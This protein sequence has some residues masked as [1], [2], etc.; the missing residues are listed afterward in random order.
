MARVTLVQKDQ[1]SKEVEEVFR[2]IEGNG[3]RVLNLYKAVAVSPPMLS[4][5]LKLGNRLL[6][7]AELSSKLRELAILR[8]ANLAGS[9]YEWTQHLSIALATGVSQQQIDDVHSW[10]ESASFTEEE[11][12]VLQYTDELAVDVTVTEGTFDGLRSHLSERQ[13]VELTL[14]IGYW[15]MVARV[16]VPLKVDLDERHVGTA[17]DLLGRADR[18]K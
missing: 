10:R 12:A 17:K 14:S 7:R 11:R 3:A 8:V 2:K 13:I 1:A 15:G 9:E 18:Q 16:L 4:S 6:S 5:F